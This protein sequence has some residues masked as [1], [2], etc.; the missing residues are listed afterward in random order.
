MTELR[1]DEAL[2]DGFAIDE[3]AK[4]FEPFLA[5]ERERARGFFVLRVSLTEAAAADGHVEADAAAELAN[6][7]LGKTIERKGSFT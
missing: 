7:A 6:Y 3:A 1:F 4:V 2:Y 5:I